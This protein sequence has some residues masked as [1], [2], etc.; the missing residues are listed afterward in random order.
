[1]FCVGFL[2]MGYLSGST[3]ISAS[4]SL[5]RPTGLEPA[6]SGSIFILY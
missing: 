3:T 5:H 1:M 2:V 6:I 4:G